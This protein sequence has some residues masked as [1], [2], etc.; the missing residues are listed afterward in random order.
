MQ[1]DIVVKFLY[2]I[3]SNHA[4]GL[5]GTCRVSFKEIP[6][7]L[8]GQAIDPVR[9]SIGVFELRLPQVRH[10]VVRRLSVLRPDEKNELALHHRCRELAA[11]WRALRAIALFVTGRRSLDPGHQ[12]VFGSPTLCIGP[13]LQCPILR[14][15]LEFQLR[16]Y[17]DPRLLFADDG[18]MH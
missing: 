7:C 2:E 10:D 4:I 11:K 18:R 16:H 3:R 14:D 15:G 17:R 8:F 12:L 1:S 9:Q 6:I 5:D 13:D